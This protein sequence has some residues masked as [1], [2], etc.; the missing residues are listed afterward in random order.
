MYNLKGVNRNVPSTV[1]Q[2]PNQLS[3]LLIFFLKMYT[4]DCQGLL[5]KT[6]I[7]FKNFVIITLTI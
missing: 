3:L 2:P 7:Y 6:N 1:A 5:N 4:A